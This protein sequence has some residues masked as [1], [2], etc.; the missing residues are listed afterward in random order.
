M[1]Q[2]DAY[3]I[4]NLEISGNTLR[5]LV[6]KGAISKVE[7][8]TIID[9]TLNRLSTLLETTDLGVEHHLE[10]LRASFQ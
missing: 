4:A 7:A 5:L 8:L 9:D 6:D 1:S 10:N 2:T 3:L